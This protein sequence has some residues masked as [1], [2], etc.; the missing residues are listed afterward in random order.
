MNQSM[1]ARAEPCHGERQRV[2]VMVPLRDLGI[3]EQARLGLDLTGLPRTA[4]GTARPAPRRI[5]ERNNRPG[6]PLAPGGR[7]SAPGASQDQRAEHLPRAQLV[8]G[9]PG[10]RDST[11]ADAARAQGPS[12]SHASSGGSP[13]GPRPDDRA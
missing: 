1:M 7:H 5:K 2:V 3:A 12:A 10:M 8:L 4:D 6:G 13:R 11:P 9:A